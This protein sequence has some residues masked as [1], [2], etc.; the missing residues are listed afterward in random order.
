GT[1]SNA[2][3]LAAFLGRLDQAIPLKQYALA[4]DPIS[5]RNH[6]SLGLFFLN[7]GRVD[8]AIDEFNRAL[9]LSPGY[10]GV[11]YLIG[12]ALLLKGEPEAALAAFEQERSSVWQL[13]G[14]V[15]AYH[16]LGRESDSDSTL[17]KL[18]ATYAGDAAYNIAY[19][20]AFRG[21]A[22]KAFEWLDK[23]VANN[24]PGLGNIGIQTLFASIRSDPRWV[25]FL[26]RLNLAPSQLAAIEFNVRLPD[27]T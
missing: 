23:A 1:Y 2:A 8:Q 16:A 24:D 10:F 7:S 15:M 14:T 3:T 22:D 27:S 12:T 5:P 26:E 19:V 18:I 20:Y 6:V 4:R 17:A 25:P 13:I 21:D 11:Q 9:T